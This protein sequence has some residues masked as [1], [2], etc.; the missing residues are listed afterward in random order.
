MI[1]LV[2]SRR[3]AV[4][5]LAVGGCVPLAAPPTSAPTAA[6]AGAAA[7]A[8]AVKI[9]TFTNLIKKVVVHA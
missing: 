1:L 3:W 8:A 4:P 6:A 7:A 9:P 5:C 2:D